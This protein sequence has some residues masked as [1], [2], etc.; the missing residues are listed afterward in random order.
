[1][2]DKM[3]KAKVVLG[4]GDIRD[5]VDSFR[6]VK[7]EAFVQSQGTTVLR[8]D[9]QHG[10][11]QPSSSKTTERGIDQAG[12]QAEPPVFRYDADVLNC[13]PALPILD[14]L[15]GAANLGRTL[16]IGLVL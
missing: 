12:S 7:S 10:S 1:M 13:A 3:P 14:S 9:F 4:V 6:P 2:V 15:D 11:W 8:S 16:G 5:L